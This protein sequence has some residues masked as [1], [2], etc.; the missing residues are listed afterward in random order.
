M[1][2]RTRALRD[3]VTITLDGDPIPAERGEPLATALLA[4]DKT[5]LARSPKLHRPRA[6]SCYRGGCDGCLARVDGVGAEAGA[7]CAARKPG[8]I[9]SI[10]AI[11]KRKVEIFG[12]GGRVKVEWLSDDVEQWQNGWRGQD[13]NN[14]Q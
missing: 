8:A 1:F 11:Q 5:I 12:M 4:A 9:S 3:P 14:F 6:P 10:A 2:R 13:A 7:V